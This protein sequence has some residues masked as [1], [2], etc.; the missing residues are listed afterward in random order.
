MIPGD[1]TIEINLDALGHEIASEMLKRLFA[2]LEARA[3][4]YIMALEAN[5]AR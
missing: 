1:F 2:E 5:D 4:L 3:C